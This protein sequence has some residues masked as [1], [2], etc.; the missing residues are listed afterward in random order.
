MVQRMC[1]QR[2]RTTWLKAKVS[3]TQENQTLPLDTRLHKEQKCLTPQDAVWDVFPVTAT[4]LFI[5]ILG[6]VS[7]NRGLIQLGPS[8][9]SY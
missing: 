7:L 6:S 1:S 3:V 4:C 9:Y 8:N 5:R 2:V